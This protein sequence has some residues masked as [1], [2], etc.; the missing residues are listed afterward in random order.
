VNWVNVMSSAVDALT[1]ALAA[2]PSSSPQQQ[3][4]LEVGLKDILYV[5]C[6]SAQRNVNIQKVS[7]QALP[8]SSGAGVGKS[9]VAKLCSLSSKFFKD[10]R[11]ST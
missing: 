2:T 8:S 1:H 9:L 10:K 11:Y 7:G 5:V 4:R 6:C 3:Q